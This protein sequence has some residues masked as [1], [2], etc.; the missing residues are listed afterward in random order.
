M[1]WMLGGKSWSKVEH[2]QGV[3]IFGAQVIKVQFQN[4][5][6]FLHPKARV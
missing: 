4:F 6:L 3:K 5:F 2:I 1:L